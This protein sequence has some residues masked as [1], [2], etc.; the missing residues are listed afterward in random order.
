[1]SDEL[2][3]LLCGQGS[4]VSFTETATWLKMGAGVPVERTV[5]SQEP[6]ASVD[7]KCEPGVSS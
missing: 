2:K 6:V 7:K 4:C 5:V 1:V 3:G